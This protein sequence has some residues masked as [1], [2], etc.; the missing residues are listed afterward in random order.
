MEGFC[1]NWHR[2]DF[3]GIVFLEFEAGYPSV[4]GNELVLLA[5]WF[6]NAIN[7]DVTRL[8]CEDMRAYNVFLIRVERS[9]NGSCEAAGGT[10]SRTGWKNRLPCG[11]TKREVSYRWLKLPVRLSLSIKLAVS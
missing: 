6:S 1:R 7:L 11:P 3:N 5:D 8:L 2:G 9:Q 4:G 10:K